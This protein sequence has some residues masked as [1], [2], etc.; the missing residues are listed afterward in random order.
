MRAHAKERNRAS[1][2]AHNSFLFFLDDLEH[3]SQ[4]KDTQVPTLAETVHTVQL[5]HLAGR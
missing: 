1:T 4:L 2:H 3:N 5:Q